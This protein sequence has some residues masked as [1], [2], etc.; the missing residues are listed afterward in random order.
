RARGRGRRR[1]RRRGPRRG[2]TD[3]RRRRGGRKAGRGTRRRR[4]S[5]HLGLAADQPERG[6][7][8]G[9]QRVAVGELVEGD[10]APGRAFVAEAEYAVPPL[11]E[12]IAPAGDR[13]G[14]ADHGL[15]G[16]V[17]ATEQ[18][19]RE[20]RLGA[21]ARQ[22][23]AVEGDARPVTLAQLAGETAAAALEV[24]TEVDPVAQETA[25]PSVAV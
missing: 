4:G 8:L 15:A 12:R 23:P 2:A 11:R 22:Q 9:Q 17:A 1:G 7:D 6:L 20:V 16:I 25:V 21:Q 14:R 3:S 18:A 10:Q 13:D 24:A 19:R 5:V